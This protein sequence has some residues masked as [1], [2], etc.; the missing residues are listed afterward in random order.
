[1]ACHTDGFAGIP[2]DCVA[3]H[4]DDYDSSTDPG[5]LAA[6]FSTDCR[7]CHTTNGWVPST[8]DHNAT[9]FPLTGAHRPLD[10]LACHASGYSGTP[11][12]CVACHQDDYD[13]TTDP[14]HLAAGFP[15]DCLPCHT[16][17]A[18]TPST[19]DHDPLFPI[20]NGKHAQEWNTCTD[21][22]TVPSNYAVFECI[23]CHEH[24]QSDSDDDH[25]E[26]QDYRYL[27]SECF[28]CHPRG[29]N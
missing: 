18:W 3:C 29:T 15:T 5:H 23:F 11:T 25:S 6:G 9:A 4:Q 1:M 20:Y 13:G 8:F 19:W 27:S 21:C 10:C 12:D 28:R 24:N 17:T 26:V 2:T 16:T 7:S 14:A 22:H